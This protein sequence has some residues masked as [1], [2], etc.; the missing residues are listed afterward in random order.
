MSEVSVL[1]TRTVRGYE[2]QEL[3]R[4][5]QASHVALNNIS[6]SANQFTEF[7]KLGGKSNSSTIL[8]RFI[9]FNCRRGTSIAGS[10]LG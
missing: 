3:V 7:L 10:C 6:F 8:L 2:R 1:K 4:W 5:R 9:M